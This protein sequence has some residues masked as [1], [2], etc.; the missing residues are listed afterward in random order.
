M[1]NIVNDI[2]MDSGI[3]L[4]IYNIGMNE[5]NCNINI[6]VLDSK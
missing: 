3:Y 5:Y 2:F 1:L 6:Y 4:M